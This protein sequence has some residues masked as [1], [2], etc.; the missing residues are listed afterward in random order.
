[1]TVDAVYLYGLVNSPDLETALVSAPIEGLSGPLQAL[2][3]GGV[4]LAFAPCEAAR[5]AP[6]RRLM[7]QHV[8]VLEHL[9]EFGTVLPFR[10]GHVSATPDSV[11]QMMASAQDQIA[12]NFDRVDGVSEF[13]VRVEFDREA[14]LAAALEAAPEL[15]AARDRLQT[16]G[17]G[18]RMDQI[19][20]GRRVADTLDTRRGRAQ[21]QILA[22][23]VPLV[24]AHV[25]QA[26]EDD[27][28]VLK[29]AFLIETG[30]EAA[31]TEALERAAESCGFAPEAPP[32][33]RLVG[34]TPPFN[35]VSLSLAD[36]AAAEF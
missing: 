4:S 11:A 19:D 29:A 23:L 31:F 3:A 9:M 26:P 2:E 24:R 12:A 36:A 21:K 35:F 7:K 18:S 20:L 32:K 25:L 8:A 5:I 1:M 33:V 13:G 10:F 16:R 15:V 17:G 14:A 27:I 22:A 30:T 34:P 28:Q 6:R